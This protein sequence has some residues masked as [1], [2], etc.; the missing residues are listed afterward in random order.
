M[1]KFR[2]RP[3]TIDA[4]QWFPEMGSVGG[5]EY[6]GGYREIWTIHTLEGNMNVSPGDYVITGVKGEKYPCKEEIFLLTYEA[7]EE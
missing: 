3:V 1:P 2:K 6:N 4:F 5:V 7:V